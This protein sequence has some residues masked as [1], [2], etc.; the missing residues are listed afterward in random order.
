MSCLSPELA[1]DFVVGALP[2]GPARDVESHMARCHDCRRL[3]VEIAK[4]G[5]APDTD[6]APPSA[7]ALVTSSLGSPVQALMPAI[8]GKGETT[9]PGK[10][11]ASKRKPTFELRRG[12]QIGRY[13]LLYPLGEGGMGSVYAAFDPKLDRR[14]ALKFLRTD[15]LGTAQQGHRQRL[16]RE[17][18]ALAR[19]SHPN[20]VSIY[21]VAETD[22][23]VFLAMELID[24]TNARVWRE[25]GAR[26]PSQILKV[27]RESLKALMA[28]HEQGIIHRDFKPDNVMVGA[29]GIARVTDFGLARAAMLDVDVLLADAQSQGVNWETLTQTGL[30]LGT[31]RY[32]APE[33]F[34]GLANELTDQFSFCLSMYEAL[35]GHYPF[36]T[37]TPRDL[38]PDKPIS[39]Q[40]LE[41]L[42]KSQIPD[43]LRKILLKGMT[44]NPAMRWQNSAEMDYELAHALDT[45]SQGMRW[46]ALAAIGIAAAIAAFFFAPAPPTVTK[47]AEDPRDYASEILALKERHAAAIDELPIAQKKIRKLEVQLEDAERRLALLALIKEEEVLRRAGRSTTPPPLPIRSVERSVTTRLA[48]VLACYETHIDDDEESTIRV[49]VGI[50][51]NGIVRWVAPP[52]QGNGKASRCLEG[53]LKRLTFPA[54]DS[55]TTATLFLSF[56]R[57]ESGMLAVNMRAKTR[58]A[59]LGQ[60]T[61]DARGKVLVDCSPSNPLCG[62]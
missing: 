45:S 62:L 33:Q 35:Y 47:A 27:Y 1:V 23:S 44:V 37:R 59:S 2:D 14:V 11:S 7:A 13:T 31:P 20:V 56:F 18:R 34:S 57:L 25:L 6:I 50:G 5:N 43:A 61:V 51:T 4:E 8:L 36:G 32:M 3:V 15:L 54:S 58:S 9:E 28:A 49:R 55:A 39:E 17:A 52:Y 53:S 48:E 40:I 12:L 38:A 24:G 26:S 46:G 10:R 42:S 41:P 21:D 16:V 29:D 19:L 60:V 22:G 30:V